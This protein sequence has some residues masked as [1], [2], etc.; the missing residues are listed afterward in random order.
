MDDSSGVTEASGRA[1][2]SPWFDRFAPRAV[3]I[4]GACLIVFR[5]GDPLVAR[6]EAWVNSR[7]QEAALRTNEAGLWKL[8]YEVGPISAPDSAVMF[9]DYECPFCARQELMLSTDVL[10]QLGLKVRYVNLPLE[11]I[12]PFAAL[13]ASIASCAG[14]SSQFRAVH[15][16][17][18]RTGEWRDARDLAHWL[19]SAGVPEPAAVEIAGCVSRSGTAGA[20]TQERALAAE[21]GIR[22][23]PTWIIRG[24]IVTGV[25]SPA[26]LEDSLEAWRQAQD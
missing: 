14:R 9:T 12:H 20:L 25:I 8:G 26:T 7:K 3:I 18:F 23:T 4:L 16:A 17:L 11:A 6:L 13:G 22:S 15:D 5:L 2:G 24:K 10:D 21:I 19:G 1:T